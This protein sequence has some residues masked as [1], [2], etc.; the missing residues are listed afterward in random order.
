M[1][2][3]RCAVTARW[4]LVVDDLIARFSVG[5]IYCKDYAADIC[6]LAVGEFPNTVSELMQRALYTV[7]TWCGKVGLSVNPDKTKLVVFTK[8]KLFGFFEPLVLGVTLHH[9]ESVRHLGVT[10]D[11]WL[12]W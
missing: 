12:T 7:E 4:C 10:L 2:T 8:R 11:S 5:R 1:P 9:S 6:L 3:G